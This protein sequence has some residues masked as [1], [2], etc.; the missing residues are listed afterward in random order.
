VSI[1]L[2]LDVDCT[3]TQDYIQSGFAKLL[4]VHK[5]YANIERQYQANQI[6][7][8]EFADRLIQL[9]N[10]TKK[11]SEEFA[12]K[13]WH[14]I[15]LAPWADELLRVQAPTA[16]YLV[17]SGPNYYIQSLAEKYEIPTDN[18]LC[19]EYIFKSGK[20]TGCMARN[21]N[22]KA[23]FVKEKGGQHL[24]TIGVGDS[25]GRDGPFISNCDVAILTKP[26]ESYL[27]ADLGKV[28]ALVSNLCNRFPPAHERPVVFIGSS[29]EDSKAA[30]ALNGALNDLKVPCD[31]KL[32]RHIF[33]PSTTNIESLEQAVREFDFAAFIMAPD[34]ITLVRGTQKRTVRDNV[35][36][37]LALCIGCLGR[38]RCFMIYPQGQRPDLPTDL[39][40]VNLVDYN[41]DPQ[42]G[43]LRA[44]LGDAADRIDDALRKLGCR[45]LFENLP[46]KSGVYKRA[47]LS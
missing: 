8:R 9:F 6:N 25:P 44:S 29:S 42:G 37:E 23:K 11:F 7:S 39:A 21:D 32:W 40:G 45:T 14:N 5:A 15:E 26:S 43:N 28:R 4:K 47:A 38:N 17:S 30:A 20:L 27:H 1:G 34:D 3:L 13:N 22:D 19:S 12:K 24:I 41:A 2:F 31:A 16:T 10:S 18:V 35:M 33:K 46:A 36:F